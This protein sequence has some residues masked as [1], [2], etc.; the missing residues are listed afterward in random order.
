MKPEPKP[1]RITADAES[2]EPRFVSGSFRRS[3]QTVDVGNSKLKVRDTEEET[4]PEGRIIPMKAS[5]NR[6]SLKPSL[7]ALAKWMKL[8]TEHLLQKDSRLGN[9][10][11]AN[12]D[13]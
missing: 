11:H 12:F 9:V 13:V 8:P 6:G 1:L 5:L 7:S 4:N 10:R 2:A 3:P